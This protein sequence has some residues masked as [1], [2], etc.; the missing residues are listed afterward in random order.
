MNKRKQIFPNMKLKHQ[1]IILIGIAIST[2]MTFFFAYI[3]ILTINSR[4][5][6]KTYVESSVNQ[7]V[8]ELN[9]F[10]SDIKQVITNFAYNRDVE[11]FS[12]SRDLGE[13][14]IV[15]QDI[16]LILDTIQISNPRV[17]AIVFTDMDQVILGT[18][19]DGLSRLIREMKK[20]ADQLE[21]KDELFYV[22]VPE[23]RILC[24][25]KSYYNYEGKK[26]YY[27]AAALNM[28][29]LQT[30][31][32]GMNAFDKTFFEILDE[33]GNTVISN[34]VAD[35]KISCSGMTVKASAASGKWE[36]KGVTLPTGINRNI[37]T[38]RN[39]MTM[40]VV[41]MSMVLCGLGYLI[42][43]GI[44]SP[45]ESLI[46]FMNEYGEYYNKNRLPV[47]GSNEIAQISVSVNKMLDNLQVM[48]RKIVRTQEQLYVAE[49]AKKQAELTAL[50]IQMNP[51]FLYN[52]LDCIRGMALVNKLPEIAEIATSMSKILRYSI[53]SEEQVLVKQEV[54]SIQDYLKI[55]GIRHQNKY[56][57][58]VSVEKKIMEFMIP[59]MILQP[60]VE[61][62]VFYGL[63]R[64]SG[65]GSLFVK[66]SQI[67]HT[68]VFV[69]ENSGESISS[70]KV[71]E[72]VRIFEE[73]QKAN[74]GTLFSDK[75]SIGLQNIDKRLKLLYG[76]EYGLLIR[77]R[78]E[79]GTKVTIKVPVLIPENIPD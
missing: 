27:V 69:V 41:G 11:K 40:I 48:T 20:K 12:M 42:Y 9:T 43:K 74:S 70:E 75:K 16:N 53:K 37:K 45:V 71:E 19:D 47:L 2:L 57:V 7:L 68:L 59:K 17:D 66:G 29:N 77:Q 14:Y 44:A 1:I 6:R 78:P 24:V 49:L 18:P 34:R 52:T 73:N 60:I 21:T 32:N 62:A 58:M 39:V 5:D 23:G 4:R 36:V 13:R 28:N 50:Q 31:V 51:H 56:D 25:R 10:D 63:E 64:Q 55:I 15:S 30:S 22:S 67:D 35:E 61:N 33:K 46:Q 79:G 26:R 54:N 72:L 65:K 38:S 3:S 76:E 8:T